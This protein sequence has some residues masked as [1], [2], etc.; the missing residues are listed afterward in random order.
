VGKIKVVAVAAAM[1]VV[2]Y[3]GAW[4]APQTNGDTQNTEAKSDLDSVVES[5]EASSI[6][7]VKLG[8]ALP[9]VRQKYPSLVC[10]SKPLRT[11]CI[12]NEITYGGLRGRALYSFDGGRVSAITVDRLDSTGFAKITDALIKRLGQPSSKLAE[13]IKASPGDLVWSQGSWTFTVTPNGL[14]QSAKVVLMDNSRVMSAQTPPQV[15]ATNV[16]ATYK[17]PGQCSAVTDCDRLGGQAYQAGHY[18]EAA[19]YYTHQVVF[20]EQD[21]MDCRNDQRYEPAASCKEASAVPFNNVAMA[22]L[23]EGDPLVAK[24]WLEVA[25]G[26][27]QTAHNRVLVNKAL[28][29]F[30]WPRSP[31]GEYWQYAGFDLWST[32]T[33]TPSGDGFDVSFEGYSFSGGGIDSGPNSG[34]LSD[35][36]KILNGVGVMHDQ[37]SS[38]CAV[39][40]TF[41]QDHVDLATQGDCPFGAN[42]SAEGTYIRVKA[43]EK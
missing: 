34:R 28:A 12:D 39:T 16:Q 14:E 3:Q 5:L 18:A 11:M 35:H 21:A 43:Y 8:E 26:S 42:V 33:V 25:P 29:G 27:P 22:T 31:A 37:D 30:R 15:T 10:R 32:L 36:I 20:A 1:M 13:M 41:S 9:M 4:G 19:A 2:G 40:A 6:N 23:H 7:G 38:D 17:R 24:A